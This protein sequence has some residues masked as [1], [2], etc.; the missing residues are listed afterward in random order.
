MNLHKVNAHTINSE[1]LGH[2]IYAEWMAG[3]VNTSSLE[4]GELTES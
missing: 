3:T 2:K 1:C 4:G